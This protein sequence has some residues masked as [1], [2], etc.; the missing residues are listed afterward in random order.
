M[1]YDVIVCGNLVA[2]IIGRP[3]N[4]AEDLRLGSL[5]FV[6]EIRLFTGGLGCN[7]A[8]DLAKL[9]FK[10]GIIGR[11]GDDRW[12]DLFFSTLEH[13]GVDREGIVIDRHHPS[14][15]TM[16]C[17][18]KSGERTF[19]HVVG[20]HGYLN[21][22]DILR[23]LD[24]IRK[25][26]MIAIGY[27]SMMPS[28]EPNLPDVLKTIKKE[29][30]AKILIDTAGSVGPQLEDL[31]RSFQYL[32]FFIPSL[33]EARVLTGC[34]EPSNMVS[35]FRARG[36][37][38]FLGV[39]LGELGCYITSGNES[40]T[41]PAFKV[42]NVVDT[43]GAGDAFLSGM[44]AGWLKGMDL[45]R[46]AEFANMVGACCVQAMG[47]STGVRSYEETL[48]RIELRLVDLALPV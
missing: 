6:D 43:T 40:V 45:K 2:D 46:T 3:V 47:A 28:L 22:D 18:D 27:Y 30:N 16:V 29:T 41:V 15:A 25:A 26:R 23:R 42:Q 38:G 48:K 10:V 37:T 11:V 20:A 9:G 24:I 19:F 33:E 8:I 1:V 32:D 7:L 4:L 17:V 5:T 21:A 12:K 14:S 44:I 34:T 39:K 35:V 13:E 36:A 31:S